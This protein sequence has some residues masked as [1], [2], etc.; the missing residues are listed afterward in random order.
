MPVSIAEAVTEAAEKLRTS[1]V[2][3]PRRDAALL[4]SHTLGCD[5]TFVIAH[6]DEAV[7]AEKLNALREYVERRAA[8]EPLQYITGHQEFFKLDF[9][10]A[11]AV[12]IPRPETELIVEAVLDLF[13]I[14]SHFDFADVGTGSGCLA[15]SILHER[16]NSQ[17]I[18]IDISRDALNVAE[19][20]AQRHN[21]DDR[22]Q[23]LESDLFVALS[24]DRTFD[25]IV[26]NPPY[27]LDQ[28]MNQL[29][30]EVQREPRSALAGGVDGLD[31]IRRLLRDAPQHLKAG[32]YLL[33]EFGVDQDA[34]IIE[35]VNQAG[36][37]LIEIRKDLQQ[38]PRMIVLRKN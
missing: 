24:P 4:L 9:E 19:R 28:E 5:R 32:G 1:G 11:P 23:L 20:N 36:W 29:Q 17:G 35:L 34:K 37:E 7:P 31:V 2:D 14:D 15:I 10:V 22:L 6:G 8:R 33:F 16:S 25:L 13:P 26:S 21:V 38:I 3:E 27:V 12:L 18:A 30:R